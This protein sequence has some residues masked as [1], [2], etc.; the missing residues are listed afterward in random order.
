MDT[1]PPLLPRS[2]PA[3]LAAV[4]ERALLL[5]PLQLLVP[6]RPSPTYSPT[7]LLCPV[8]TTTTATARRS[9]SKIAVRALKA[10]AHY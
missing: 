3:Q 1:R 7:A 8:T 4:S 5:P 10:A 9:T 2:D 6:P